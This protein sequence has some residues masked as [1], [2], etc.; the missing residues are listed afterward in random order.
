[1]D[2]RPEIDSLVAQV[3]RFC[4]S[5]RRL[6]PEARLRLAARLRD[7]LGQVVETAIDASMTAAARRGWGL[8][9]IGRLVGLSHE[10]VR[11]RIGRSMESERA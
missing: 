4:G 2:G 3:E 6:S 7:E 5:L 8:R 1:M 9:R 11:S 10:T